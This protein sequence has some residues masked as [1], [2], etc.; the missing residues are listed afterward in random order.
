METRNLM[1]FNSA[2]LKTV[3]LPLVSVAASCVTIGKQDVKNSN[4]F[5]TT[6]DR[7]VVQRIDDPSPVLSPYGRN[8]WLDARGARDTSLKRIHA[9]LA[10]GEGLAAEKDARKY[11]ISHPGDIEGMTALASALAQSGQYDLAA[12]YARI[13]ASKLPDNPHSLNIQGLALLVNGGRIDELKRAESLFQRAFD[14]S[15]AEV[16]AG[17]NLGW[18]YLELGNPANAL[19]VFEQVQSRCLDCTAALMGYG[20]ASKRVGN[21]DESR[22]AFERVL[23]KKKDDS[24]ALYHL[25]LVYRDGLNNKLKAEEMLKRVLASNTGNAGIKEKAST[26]LGTLRGENGAKDRALALSVPDVDTIGELDINERST[27]SKVATNAVE[28]DTAPVRDASSD[29]VA[30]GEGLEN[31][32]Y[33]TQEAEAGEEVAPRP[34]S[35]EAGSEDF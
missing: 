35:I 14:S 16:A 5:E 2:L 23:K 13:V 10:T 9:L 24:E 11:L 21:F 7:I 28:T 18:L 20:I 1:I 22:V 34:A 26:V 25:G 33:S 15:Q 30:E 6:P 12:Y 17:L 31:A 27:T 19:K 32:N 3:A 8:Y 29:K 4:L